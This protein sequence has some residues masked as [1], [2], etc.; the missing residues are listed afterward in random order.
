MLFM[1]YH[2]MFLCEMQKA[3]SHAPLLLPNSSISSNIVPGADPSN[4][5][6]NRDDHD[7]AYRLEHDHIYQFGNSSCCHQGHEV[8]LGALI[9]AGE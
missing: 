6:T 3:R 8:P 2:I 4:H 9:R 7:I 1:S 5:G